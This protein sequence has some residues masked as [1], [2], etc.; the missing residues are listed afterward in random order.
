[1]NSNALREYTIGR[2]KLV[3]G[4][5]VSLH[6]KRGRFRFQYARHLASGR[7]E[8]TFVGGSLNG[9]HDLYVSAYPER[10]KRVHRINK[11]FNNIHKE[12]KT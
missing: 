2:H 4:T 5:E 6:G 11:T 9:M 8:L 1:M 3:A 10:V 12:S 7:D